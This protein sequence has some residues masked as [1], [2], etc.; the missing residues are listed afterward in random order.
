MRQRR[1]AACRCVAVDGV[2]ASLYAALRRPS[3]D[4]CAVSAPPVRRSCLSLTLLCDLASWCQYH[5][6]EAASSA[7]AAAGAVPYL[8]QLM[9]DGTPA[10]RGDSALALSRMLQTVPS[11][12]ASAVEG[13]ECTSPPEIHRCAC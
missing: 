2:E 3:A 8:L 12:A 10:G 7:I 6:G 1:S 9:R 4:F 11:H 13:G 5:V